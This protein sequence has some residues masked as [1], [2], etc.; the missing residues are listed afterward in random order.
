[1]EK[2]R[3]LPL[4]GEFKAVPFKEDVSHPCISLVTSPLV[5][6]M[7]TYMAEALLNRTALEHKFDEF[8]VATASFP[9]LQTVMRVISEMHVQQAGSEFLV[10]NGITA[11]PI[12]DNYSD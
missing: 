8:L 2:F 6:G 7:T 3:Q 11:I 12:P 5:E 10:N 1:M 9:Q 4:G